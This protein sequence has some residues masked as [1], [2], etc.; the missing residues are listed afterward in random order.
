MGLTAAGAAIVSFLLLRGLFK[1]RKQLK[2]KVVVIT[3][4]SSGIGEGKSVHNA[5]KF[6]LFYL[7]N[8][9]HMHFY[10]DNNL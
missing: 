10:S 1:Q 9:K 3:G 5:P 7:H 6:T 4:A 2:G 8:M